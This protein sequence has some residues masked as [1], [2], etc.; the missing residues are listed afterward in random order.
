MWKKKYFEEVE[1]T[2]TK[3][4]ITDASIRRPPTTD[5]YMKAWLFLSFGFQVVW[6]RRRSQIRWRDIAM[7][8]RKGTIAPDLSMHRFPS[9]QP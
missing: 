5:A 1:N 7:Y 8:E 6:C 2:G 9:D 4:K 3:K